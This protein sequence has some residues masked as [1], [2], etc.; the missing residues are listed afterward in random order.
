MKKV[1]FSRPKRDRKSVSNATLWVYLASK[2]KD[3]R[4]YEEYSSV[5]VSCS[6]FS[7]APRFSGQASTETRFGIT[8]IVRG[9]VVGD[10]GGYKH[11]ELA[12]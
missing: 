6:S 3:D 5:V 7:L 12:R 11:P 9:I 4:K 2:L 10:G 8:S 1:L